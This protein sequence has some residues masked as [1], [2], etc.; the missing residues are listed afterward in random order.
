MR[1]ISLSVL[2][3]VGAL[4]CNLAGFAQENLVNAAGFENG[5]V[6]LDYTSEYGDRAASEWIALGLIDGTTELGWSSSI[7]AGFPQEFV[8]ELS[9][10]YDIQQLS[11]ENTGNEERTNPGISARTVTVLAATESRDGP[12]E[13]IYGGD[14]STEST[15]VSLDTPVSARWLKLSITANG[16]HARYT[17]LMEFRALGVSTAEEAREQKRVSG[18]YETNWN[19]FYLIVEGNTIRG[20]YD[21]DDGVFDGNVAGRFLNIEWRERG[22]Q[23]G[24]AVL[25]IVEDGS[26]FNGFWYEDGELRGTWIGTRTDDSREPACATNLKAKSNQVKDALEQTGRAVLYG[27]YFDH[28]SDV[29]KPESEPTLNNVLD[30]LRENPEISMEFGGHTDA[31]GSDEYNVSLSE[32]RAQSVVAWMSQND[33]AAE[34]LAAVGYGESRPVANNTSAHGK[35]LNRRVEVRT[36]Q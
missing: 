29:L 24:K 13:K 27:I 34:R 15:S 31:D 8:I 33:I 18:T 9:Q 12:F 11:F 21:Y 26:R 1:I 22:P 2:L 35:A 20:C 19:P 25:A 3:G 6:L 30:W 10:T 36:E 17:E 7:D 28:D 5:A 16:G 14:I 23:I 32:R 4:A